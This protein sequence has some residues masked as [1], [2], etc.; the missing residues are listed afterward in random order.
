MGGWLPSSADG[1][2]RIRCY[3]LLCAQKKK[4]VIEDYNCRLPI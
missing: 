3:V 1:V 4:A 2:R